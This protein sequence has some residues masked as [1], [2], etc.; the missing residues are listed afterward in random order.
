MNPGAIQTL[1]KIPFYRYGIPLI[2]LAVLPLLI[3]YGCKGVF[4]KSTINLIHPRWYGAG[5]VI[6]PVDVTGH[7]LGTWAIV[8]GLAYLSAALILG[9]ILIPTSIA[10]LKTPHLN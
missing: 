1:A 6:N 9:Y 4:C 7:V 2:T 5:S 10:L 8:Y 3:F